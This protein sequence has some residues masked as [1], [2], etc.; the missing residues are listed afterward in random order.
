MAMMLKVELIGLLN[1]Y[2]MDKVVNV[3]FLGENGYE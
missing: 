1:V 2:L 3:I